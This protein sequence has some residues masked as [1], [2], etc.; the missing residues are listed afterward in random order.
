MSTPAKNTRHRQLRKEKPLQNIQ[1]GKSIS[2]S[3]KDNIQTGRKSL[4]FLKKTELINR[5]L[6][7]SNLNKHAKSDSAKDKS[8]EEWE[9]NL[10]PIHTDEGSQV[11]SEVS[12]NLNR[13]IVDR[14]EKGNFLSSV[15][16]NI[17]DNSMDEELKSVGMG[18][19]ASV[20]SKMQQRK[21]ERARKIKEMKM[22]HGKIDASESRGMN[23]VKTTK[24]NDEW[25]NTDYTQNEQNDNDENNG[26]GI[27][28]GE[29]SSTVQEQQV[30]AEV[31]E[32]EAS[33]HDDTSPPPSQKD[34]EDKKEKENGSKDDDGTGTDPE[35]EPETEN[36]IEEFKKRLE[37]EDTSVF[38][39]MFQLLITKMS[40]L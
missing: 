39:D 20:S 9:V 11:S 16:A 29:W 6:E 5:W 4:K 8:T 19:S 18:S 25:A 1:Y 10:I 33:N 27:D 36:I 14:E 7:K 37:K 3:S 12:F 35:L 30:Q 40:T 2:S 28:T 23:M 17:K 22:L 24:V 34:D 32:V 31:N 21:V 26:S 38:F 15:N 13:A